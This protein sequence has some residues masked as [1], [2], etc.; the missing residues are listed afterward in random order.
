MTT[1]HSGLSHV[2]HVET[3]T[4]LL[5]IALHNQMSH[6][7]LATTCGRLESKPRVSIAT[8]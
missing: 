8:S 6:M 5:K 3:Y 1:Y 4:F 7:A 2:T